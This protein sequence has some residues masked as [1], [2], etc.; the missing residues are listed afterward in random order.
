MRGTK[1]I[2]SN[3]NCCQ[4]R[5]WD[6]RF[7]FVS[8]AGRAYVNVFLHFE[9]I[10]PLDDISKAGPQENGL[11]PYVIPGGSWEEEA[12][13]GGRWSVVSRKLHQLMA[14][15]FDSKSYKLESLFTLFQ[16]FCCA[17]R[18]EAWRYARFGIHCHAY[19]RKPDP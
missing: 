2:M 8:S 4:Q 16:A 13:K 18:L 12:L 3:N 19:T 17:N 14:Q 11:P 1:N 10:G 5:H 7:L 9:P 6:S 15:L